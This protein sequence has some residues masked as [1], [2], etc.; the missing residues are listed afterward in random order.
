MGSYQLRFPVVNRPRRYGSDRTHFW[1]FL[2]SFTFV[3]VLVWELCLQWKECHLWKLWD[4]PSL[5]VQSLIWTVSSMTF[6]DYCRQPV[7]VLHGLI[8]VTKITKSQYG[9]VESSMTNLTTPPCIELP[10]HMFEEYVSAVSWHKYY[11]AAGDLV[12]LTQCR[13]P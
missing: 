7:T 10:C 11:M 4:R 5:A 1:Y 6:I 3:V 2:K 8:P 13:H 12:V 9:L